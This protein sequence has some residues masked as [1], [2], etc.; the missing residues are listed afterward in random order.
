[1]PGKDKRAPVRVVPQE[2]KPLMGKEEGKPLMGK[3]VVF[4]MPLDTPGFKP[5]APGKPAAPV[6][7]AKKEEEV[8]VVVPEP[9]EKPAAVPE[10][11]IAKAA[12][13]PTAEP[14][15]GAEFTLT[16]QD[17]LDEALAARVEPY[18]EEMSEMAAVEVLGTSKKKGKR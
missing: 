14:V 18:A 12:P 8:F 16:L 13:T 17:H 11:E 6:K 1:M 4:S 5:A 3:K 9:D 7:A 10:P 15:D 2:V